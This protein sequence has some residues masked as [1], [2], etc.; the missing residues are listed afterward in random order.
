MP[1][2]SFHFCYESYAV[3]FVILLESAI[4]RFSQN[5]VCLVCR[6]LLI[7]LNNVVIL[8]LEHSRTYHITNVMYTC[9]SCRVAFK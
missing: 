3:Y 7:A 5:N 6:L 8:C 1:S 9:N 2:L 4:R